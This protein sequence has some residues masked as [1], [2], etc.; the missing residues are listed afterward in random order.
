VLFQLHRLARLLWPLRLWCLALALAGAAA[1][2]VALG[3]T[4]ATPSA[5]LRLSL[6]FTLWMLLLYSYIQLFRQIPSPVLPALPWWERAR[7][8]L[9]LWC[10][11]VLAAG[12]AVTGLI[13]VGI[14]LKLWFL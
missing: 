9:H 7:Q 14:S 11:Y 13:L 4:R 3:E 8:R 12:V 1:A 6:L 5:T 10:Y 2:G